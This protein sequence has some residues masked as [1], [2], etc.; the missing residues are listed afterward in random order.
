[1]MYD[2]L[3]EQ[4]YNALLQ[5]VFFDNGHGELACCP[6]HRFMCHPSPN[7]DSIPNSE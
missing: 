6:C 3:F 7:L 2:E 1:M 4:I 5:L